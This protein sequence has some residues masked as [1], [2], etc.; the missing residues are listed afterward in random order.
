MRALI[1][2]IVVG[3]MAWAGWWWLASDTAQKSA[4]AWFE[5]RRAEG[6]RAENSGIVV[7]G[8]PN[9]IDLTIPDLA[10]APPKGGWSWQTPF[11]QI[12][13][14]SYKPWHLIAA[15]ANEQSFITPAGPIELT[16]ETLQA[17]L[18]V[19]PE[20]QARLDRFQVIANGLHA[21]TP[22]GAVSAKGISIATRQAVDGV[23]AH[24]IGLS[25][26]EVTLPQ[27]LLTSLAGATEVPSLIEEI[28][29]NARADLSAPLDRHAAE[30]RPK[31]T[32]LTLREFRVNWGAITLHASGQLAPDA[33]GLAEGAFEL[34]LTGYE[35]L[36]RIAQAQGLVSAQQ[37]QSLLPMLSA[38]AK[39][40]VL[41]VPVKL[42]SGR[43]AIAGLPMAQGLGFPKLQ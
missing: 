22:I 9:R 37:S 8:F 34:R 5:D 43:L 30:I 25:A 16:T 41:T 17:S 26:N 18:V 31:L 4:V 33:A 15:V 28:H 38:M 11:V 40:G 12:F 39:D 32:G 19:T 36:L 35:T 10:L 29:L 24:D 1:G 2:L 14:L 3:F 6:W 7:Q 13:A 21:T 42:S 20:T 27:A 23:N